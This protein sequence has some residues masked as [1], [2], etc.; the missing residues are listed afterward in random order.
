MSKKEFLGLP[1]RAFADPCSEIG[2]ETPP[3]RWWYGDTCMAWDFVIASMLVQ[4]RTGTGVPISC[5]LAQ[6]YLSSW[7]V[8]SGMDAQN[9]T[10]HPNPTGSIGQPKSLETLKEILKQALG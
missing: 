5:F 6:K 3:L 1:V 2:V 4:S 10:F 7:T 8:A 9:T